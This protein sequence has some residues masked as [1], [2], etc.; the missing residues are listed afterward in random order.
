MDSETTFL[1]TLY[2]NQAVTP[3]VIYEAKK[4]GIIGVK[5]YPQGVTTNSDAGVVSYE[6]FYPVFAAMEEVDMVLNLHGEK[7]PAPETTVLNAEEQFLP[8]LLDLHARFPK[9]RIVLEHCTTAAAVEA[10]KKCGPTVAATITSH[11]LWL[12]VNDWAGNPHCFCKPVAKNP[13]DR[14]ALIDAATSG[15]PKF[16]LGTDSAPHPK[17]AKHGSKTAAGVFTQPYA[18]QYVAEIFENAGKLDKLRGFAC[19]FGREFYKVKELGL[20]KK[21]GTIVL[22][23]EPGVEIA[24]EIGQGDFAVIPFLTGQRTWSLE[25]K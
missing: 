6:A 23:K 15:N 24:Q 5:S 12:T 10:V 20:E 3:E 18:L 25:W 14:Q 1:M 11:H 16:F 9:L 8:T 7:P 17:Q 2:L 13:S 4:A 22:K 19:E 21:T